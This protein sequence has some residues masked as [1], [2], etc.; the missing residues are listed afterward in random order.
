VDDTTRVKNHVDQDKHQLNDSKS[1]K[2]PVPL[3]FHFPLYSS[4]VGDGFPTGDIGVGLSGLLSSIPK[5]G[6]FEIHCFI[7]SKG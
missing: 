1:I 6:K 7:S 5:R 2:D 4:F 3:N